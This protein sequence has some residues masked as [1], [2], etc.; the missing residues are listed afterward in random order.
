MK[1]RDLEKHL[2]ECGCCFVREGGNHT[3]WKNPATGK[4]APV[5]RHREVKEGTV[6]A[7]CKQLEISRP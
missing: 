4:V 6:R 1:L 7:I 3:L 2:K 5:P